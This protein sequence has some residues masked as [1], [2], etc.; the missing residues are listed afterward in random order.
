MCP[1]ARAVLSLSQRRRDA[2]RT[3]PAAML[4]TSA[5]RR[6]H[7]AVLFHATDDARPRPGWRAS[8]KTAGFDPVRPGGVAASGRIEVGGDLHAKGGLNGRLLHKE[9]ASL[10][11]T[12]KQAVS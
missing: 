10:L 7:P 8:S 1:T 4:S 12:S 5:N 6:P 2:T 9:A 11:I 3:L